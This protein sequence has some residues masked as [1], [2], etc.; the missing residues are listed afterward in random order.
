[1]NLHKLSTIALGLTFSSTVFAQTTLIKNV[2]GY[3]INNNELVKFHAIQI[4]DDKIDKIFTQSIKVPTN[5]S[6]SILSLIHI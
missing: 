1:M 3:T 5:L 4:T 2:N 6:A